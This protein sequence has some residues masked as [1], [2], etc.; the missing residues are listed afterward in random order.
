LN[1]ALK[2]SEGK[3]LEAHR[4]IDA[5]K[6]DLLFATE[7]CAK[8][9]ARTLEAELKLEAANQNMVW[10]WLLWRRPVRNSRRKRKR[11]QRRCWH[12]C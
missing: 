4:L 8:Q 6:A 11:K 7:L 3:T 10:S 5:H 9:E 2:A 12:K 1:A